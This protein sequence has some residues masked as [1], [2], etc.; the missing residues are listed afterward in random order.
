MSG[1]PGTEPLESVRIVREIAAPAQRVYDA[2]IDPEM[3][4]RWIGPEKYVASRVEVD[5]RVGGRAGVWGEQADGSTGIFNWDFIEMV[6][7]ERL[8]LS[9]A[10]AD[11][12]KEPDAHR[13]LL[14]LDLRETSPGHTELT[15]IHERLKPRSPQDAKGVTRGWGQVLGRL[16]AYLDST[17]EEG[18]RV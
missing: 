10:F 2:W 14:T 7:A 11:R 9:F 6:P 16:V 13:S 12:D 1:H 15:L 4:I 5:P 18:A 8:V 17:N 3:L